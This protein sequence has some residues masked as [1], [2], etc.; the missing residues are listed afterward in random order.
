[1]IS[2][3]ASSL[4]LIA[5]WVNN[6]RVRLPGAT[7]LSNGSMQVHYNY[8]G[9][10][11]FE[12]LGIPVLLGRGP[13]K[14]DAAR[15]PRVAFV[16]ESVAETAF[17]GRSPLG[18]LIFLTEDEDPYEIVGVVADAHFARVKRDPPPTVYFSRTSR[19]REASAA[20]STSLCE[21]P[22][23]RR[24]LPAPCERWFV[25]LIRICRS[26]TWPPNGAS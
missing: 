9:P 25:S 7:A 21:P 12:T 14:R 11:F 26:S 24:R 4:R 19:L 20:L 1:M 22:D 6:T 13:E 16:N 18:E 23:H 17:P 15:S 3:T 10:R 8:V 2:A 5:R